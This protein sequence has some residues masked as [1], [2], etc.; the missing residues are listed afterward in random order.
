MIKT[1]YNTT[2]IKIM[3]KVQGLK[4]MGLK[5]NNTVASGTSWNAKIFVNGTFPLT[6]RWTIEYAQSSPYAPPEDSGT[7]TC[8]KQRQHIIHP[9]SIDDEDHEED[10]SPHECVIPLSRNFSLEGS[11]RIFI[12]AE[13]RLSR[14]NETIYLWV[15]S[16]SHFPAFAATIF[17]PVVFFALVVG[18]LAFSY[19]CFVYYPHSRSRRRSNFRYFRID[20]GA[21]SSGNRDSHENILE[22]PTYIHLKLR[23]DLGV[24]EPWYRRGFANVLNGEAEETDDDDDGDEAN[25][26]TKNSYQNSP[27]RPR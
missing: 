1:G 7:H 16:T 27:R 9:S 14:A 17:F 23:Q 20:D 6:I 26:F 22:G 4:L 8:T 25:V 19:Y 15:Y 3:E 2:R 10:L 13:N 21:A 11:Y 5:N 24:V 12:T 18:T